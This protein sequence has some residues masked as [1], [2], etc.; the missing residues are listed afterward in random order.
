MGCYRWEYSNW[1]NS[2]ERNHINVLELNAILLTLKSYFMHNCNIK[3]VHILTGNSTALTC[4]NNMGGMHSV[5]YNDIAEC[6]WESAQNRGFGFLQAT[7][8]VQRTQWQ[9]KYLESSMTT[10][11]TQNEY[12]R[13][14]VTNFTLALSSISLPSI[15]TNRQTNMSPEYQT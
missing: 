4:I 7:F 13:T 10:Q 8:L 2:L 14:C 9:T 5:P 15:S 11:K 12:S 3:H 1:W 6:I